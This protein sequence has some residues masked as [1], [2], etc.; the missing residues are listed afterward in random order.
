MIR[1]AI[2]N[3]GRM[4]Q[5][6]LGFLEA[7]GL[8]IIKHERALWCHP[9]ENVQVVFANAK[10]IPRYLSAGLIQFGITG[11]DILL[12]HQLWD[13]SYVKLGFARCKL[14][15]AVKESSSFRDIYDLVG[16]EGA[17]SYPNIM[18]DF[19]S[20]KGV[21]VINKSIGGACELA[22]W[23]GYC[24][25]IVDSYQSGM[26]ATVNNLRV[27]TT[28]MESEAVLVWSREINIDYLWSSPFKLVSLE[29]KEL[30]DNVISV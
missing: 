16:K 26:T 19:F 5:G 25:F 27:I 28:I 12:E 7:S 20:S 6:A 24:D 2:P 11:M 22:P 17:T 21:S 18:K 13:I 3:K 9:A 30:F 29:K 15:V 10:D 4:S 8:K 14:V 23:I 1:I